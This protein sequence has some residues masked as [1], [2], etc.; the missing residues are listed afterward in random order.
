MVQQLPSMNQ[1]DGY[2][3]LFLIKEE[4]FTKR[5]VGHL[6]AKNATKRVYQIRKQDSTNR[7]TPTGAQD[8]T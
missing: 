2:T 4:E 7:K 8:K 1:L 6:H 5:G 3:N